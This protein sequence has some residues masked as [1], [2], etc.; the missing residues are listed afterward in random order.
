MNKKDQAIEELRM[1]VADLRGAVHNT[2]CYGPIP[3]DAAQLLN[4]TADIALKYKCYHGK[5]FTIES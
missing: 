5:D 1:C 4:D 2:I 3:L